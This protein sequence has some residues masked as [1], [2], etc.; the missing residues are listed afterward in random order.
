[1]MF[2]VDFV[3]VNSTWTYNNIKKI[4]NFH[5]DIH[6]LYPP[7]NIEDFGKLDIKDLK[8]R[9]KLIISFA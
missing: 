5:N 7:C 8:N 2:F 6:V 1:M 4:W 3:F 9:E